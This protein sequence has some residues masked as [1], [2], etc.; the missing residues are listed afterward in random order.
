MGPSLGG[1]VLLVGVVV[2]VEQRLEARVARNVVVR[3]QRELVHELEQLVDELH[4]LLELGL[5]GPTGLQLLAHDVGP[6]EHRHHARPVFLEVRERDSK[7]RFLNQPLRILESFSCVLHCT[8][9][10]VG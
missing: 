3:A 8:A 7:C 1:D 9:P 4:L 10:L 5:G 6:R 2:D